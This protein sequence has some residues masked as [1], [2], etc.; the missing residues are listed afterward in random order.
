MTALL[1]VEAFVQERW[2]PFDASSPHPEKNEGYHIPVACLCTKRSDHELGLGGQECTCFPIWAF[3][4][5]VCWVSGVSLERWLI[6]QGPGR[7]A[8]TQNPSKNISPV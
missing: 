6:S 7:S 5:P 8:G 1:G 3:G 2:P 4:V